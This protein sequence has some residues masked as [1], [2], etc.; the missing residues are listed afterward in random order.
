MRAYTVTLLSLFLFLCTP[1]ISWSQEP[2]QEGDSARWSVLAEHAGER[3]MI[4]MRVPGD[5]RTRRARVRT[6]LLHWATDHL[7][8][9]LS[10]ATSHGIGRGIDSDDIA[11]GRALSIAYAQ[12]G[13]WSDQMWVDLWLGAPNVRSGRGSFGIFS[14]SVDVPSMTCSN[15]SVLP[16]R[17]FGFGA[18]TS[19]WGIPNARLRALEDHMDT[20]SIARI[21]RVVRS[22]PN[23]LARAI[24][25]ARVRADK[26]LGPLLTLPNVTVTLD[27]LPAPNGTS[28]PDVLF[29]MYAYTKED[30]VARE[31]VWRVVLQTFNDPRLSVHTTKQ[32]RAELWAR[33]IQQS[34]YFGSLAHADVA[35]E[36][37]KRL[38]KSSPGVKKKSPERIDICRQVYMGLVNTR[39]LERM[40]QWSEVCAPPHESLKEGDLGKLRAFQWCVASPLTPLTLAARFERY[41]DSVWLYI[42]RILDATKN[43]VLIGELTRR[44]RARS[45]EKGHVSEEALLWDVMGGGTAAIHQQMSSEGFKTMAPNDALEWMIGT[46]GVAIKYKNTAAQNILQPLV[47]KRISKPQAWSD[48]GYPVTRLISVYGSTGQHAEQHKVFASILRHSAEPFEFL[49][50]WTYSSLIHGSSKAHTLK[51]IKLIW[52]ALPAQAAT[53]DARRDSVR[54]VHI[55]YDLML[56][57]C[58]G[59]KQERSQ[60][61]DVLSRHARKN[62][63]A[64]GTQHERTVLFRLIL[65]RKVFDAVDSLAHDLGSRAPKGSHVCE[66]IVSAS[67]STLEPNKS[68]VFNEAMHACISTHPLLTLEWVQAFGEES[69]LVEYLLEIHQVLWDRGQLNHPR[70][71]AVLALQ[72]RTIE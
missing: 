3:V 14:A 40:A 30:A 21:A 15:G 33:W 36:Q 38:L 20:W 47:F 41:D 32:E 10:K 19:V 29:W 68:A 63:V 50:R 11:H 67:S 4:H 70:V 18:S 66:H 31:Q 45:V 60:C 22:E 53:M 25:T 28:F 69:M 55:L 61:V 54:R 23:S 8:H 59:L 24:M 56:R 27:D 58:L 2:Q 35:K 71:R 62:D 64:R 44:M 6:H 13:M 26:R 49:R 5:V 16:A 65:Q 9:R 17:G 37:L 7:I 1:A 43:A 48:F 12:E 57:G 46:L 72:A 34:L 51:M 39:H 42:G 52:S